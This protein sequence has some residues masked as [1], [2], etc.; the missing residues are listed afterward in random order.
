[1]I[2]HPKVYSPDDPHLLESL[3]DPIVLFLIRS[4][5]EDAARVVIKEV[6]ANAEDAENPKKLGYYLTIDICTECL[7]RY[8]IK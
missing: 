2:P 5:W 6:E 4:A 1:M 3:R 7:R 8:P